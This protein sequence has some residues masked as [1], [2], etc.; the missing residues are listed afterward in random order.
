LL[1]APAA[2]NADDALGLLR[3]TLDKVEDQ[4]SGIPNQINPGL[5][6]NGTLFPPRDDFI[7]RL[8]NGGISARTKGN[9]LEFGSNG[10]I[11]ISDLKGNVILDKLGGG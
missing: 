11:K 5:K 10:S 4:F 7:T 3:R 6:F 8:P 1:D 2:T 9:I